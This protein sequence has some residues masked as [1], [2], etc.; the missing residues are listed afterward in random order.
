MK[1]LTLSLILFFIIFH[2]TSQVT[3]NIECQQDSQNPYGNQISMDGSVVEYSLCSLNPAFYVTIID[4]NCLPWG[5][6]YNSENI[7]NDF[8]NFNN[9]GICRAR[10]EYFFVY[11][12][13]D[14]LELVY[15]DSL[16]N[17]WIPNNHVIA[18]WTPFYYNFNSISSVCPQ[19]GNTLINKWG[20][21]VQSDSM[22]VLFGVQGISQSFSVDTLNNGVSISVTKEICPYSTLGINEFTNTNKKSIVRIV[23]LM[24]RETDNKSNTL[25]IYIYS[26]GTAEKVFRLD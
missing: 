14:S 16:L 8:G 25:L 19:L 22:I 13:T 9:N 11:R 6:S 12:Q 7:Q 3:L 4:T 1:T 5:T 2:G 20:T 23:D 18:I 24:G 15:M 26:D 10:V 21:N 17:N